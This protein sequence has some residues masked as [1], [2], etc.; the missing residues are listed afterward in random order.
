MIFHPLSLSAF[1]EVLKGTMACDT[2]NR[3]TN[4]GRGRRGPS[5]QGPSAFHTMARASASLALLL[6]MEGANSFAP[7]R[8]TS[9]AAH[10]AAFP[11]QLE[12][13][14]NGDAES[15]VMPPKTS[16]W[17]N[18]L[19]F[20][21]KGKKPS[22][23]SDDKSRAVDDYLEFLERRYHRLHDEEQQEQNRPST[24]PAKFSALKWLHQGDEAESPVL[25]Q[26]QQ[27]DA[28][29]VLGVAGLASRQLLAKHRRGHSTSESLLQWNGAPTAT[30]QPSM[31]ASAGEASLPASAAVSYSALDRLQPLARS[32]LIRRKLLLRYQARQLNLLA[33]VAAKAVATGPAKAVSALWRMG[34]GRKNIAVTL[35]VMAAFSV[36]VLRPLTGFLLAVQHA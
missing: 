8:M 25:R 36:F 33:A 3:T 12:Y 31:A 23:S 17:W 18:P 15:A 35:T 14:T 11:T 34:G 2:I 29:F 26:Q 16:R 5:Q 30:E 6:M 28:L 24:G 10:A 4:R 7:M 21:A 13:R 32:V 20:S 1:C 9:T 27:D 22:S 19:L